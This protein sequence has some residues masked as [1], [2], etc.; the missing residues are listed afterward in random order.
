MMHDEYF[1]YPRA[2]VYKVKK[3]FSI[4]FLNLLFCSFFFQTIIC[5][6]AK[7][8]DLILRISG[9]RG[10]NNWEGLSGDEQRKGKSV[11]DS[12]SSPI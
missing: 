4:F 6:I 7:K 8:Y 5:T 1:S 12:T 3:Y 9:R 11:N 2:R 10:T